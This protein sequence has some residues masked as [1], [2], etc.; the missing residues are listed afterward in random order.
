M[1][2][3]LINWDPKDT[4]EHMADTR[5]MPYVNSQDAMIKQF[6]GDYSGLV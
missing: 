6:D 5:V 4:C 1:H 2:V 3:Y